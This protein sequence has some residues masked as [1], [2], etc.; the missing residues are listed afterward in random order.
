MVFGALV[1]L[2]YFTALVIERSRQGGT[3]LRRTT[4]PRSVGLEP[5]LVPLRTF[6]PPPGGLLFQG[7]SVIRLI[8][9]ENVTDPNRP[10]LLRLWRLD[11]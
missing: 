6:R 9:R 4:P 10:H 11:P 8:W 7:T 1:L 3:A 2:I 5:R